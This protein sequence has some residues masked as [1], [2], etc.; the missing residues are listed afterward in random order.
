M[1][2]TEVIKLN[3]VHRTRKHLL[4][5]IFSQKGLRSAASLDTFQRAMPA[6]EFRHAGMVH[7]ARPYFLETLAY[8]DVLHGLK[9]TQATPPIS[10]ALMHD[11]DKLILSIQEISEG[12]E[13][14]VRNVAPSLKA[15]FQAGRV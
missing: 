5:Q 6:I 14:A 4:R 1:P 8:K 3:P 9:G 12:I 13:S 11:A 2:I 15:C 10:Y 7:K